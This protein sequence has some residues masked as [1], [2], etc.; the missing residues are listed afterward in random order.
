MKRYTVQ[1][2]KEGRRKYYYIQD[3]ESYEI[4]PLASKYLMHKIRTNRSPN[5]VKRAAFP[6]SYYLN[7][8]TEWH[9][10]Y[11]DVLALNFRD[12]SEHFIGFLYW[13]KNRKHVE[14][15]RHINNATCNAYLS[16]VFRFYLFMAASE[17]KMTGLKVLY[18]GQYDTHSSAG[19]AKKIFFKSFD[20]YLDEEERDVRPAEHA[21]ILEVLKACTN[22]RDQLLL[23][24]LAETGFRIGELLGVDY[25]RDIDY[26]NHMIR[27]S[28]RADNEN[29]ARAKN[30]EYRK[31]KISNETFDFLMY[32]MSEYKELLASQDYLFVNIAG[33]T[34]GRPLKR[35][36]VYDMLDR[37]EKKTGV[38]LTPHMLRRYFA[39]MR[40]KDGWRLELIQ[41]ALGHK[42]L[43]TTIRYLK[44]C[45]D[46]MIKASQEF[47]QR[48]AALYDVGNLL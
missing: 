44:I 21:E 1:M 27:V 39:D 23:L 8:L 32:Y 3:S 28:F 43:E 35:D 25:L 30:A 13:L 5:T 42:N 33:P 37:M 22:C 31:A 11:T 40:R 10:N 24:I 48:N 7:Y 16:E 41:Q 38:D 19:M 6:I 20:G 2:V 45:D 29:E 15:L 4:V 36:S 18:A 17:E 34:K 12:Q 14:E 9:M 26:R 47:Y 46:E